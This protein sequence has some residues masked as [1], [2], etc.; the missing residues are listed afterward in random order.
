MSTGLRVTPLCWGTGTL[1]AVKCR[2]AAQLPAHSPCVGILAVQ[3]PSSQLPC[4]TAGRVAQLDTEHNG[5]PTTPSMNVS[6][7]SG[8]TAMG[9]DECGP[10]APV[11]G[12]GG[13]RGGM[14]HCCPLDS[15]GGTKRGAALPEGQV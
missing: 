15:E 12:P 2:H 3:T 7:L 11:P 8:D 1:M 10:Q 6:A 14:T 4:A 13:H 9:A 5:A